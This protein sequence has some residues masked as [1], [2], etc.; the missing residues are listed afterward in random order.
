MVSKAFDV[1]ERLLRKL[2]DKLAQLQNDVFEHP[3]KT[4]EEFNIRLGRYLELNEIT[5]QMVH[6]AKGIE[7]DSK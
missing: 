5:Q 2:L 4:I 1:D 6:D 3:P 7:K